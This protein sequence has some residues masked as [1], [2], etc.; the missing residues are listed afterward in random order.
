M[1]DFTTSMASFNLSKVKAEFKTLTIDL[2]ISGLQAEREK[3]D[4]DSAKYK[5]IS[6]KIGNLIEQRG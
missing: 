1:G 6:T 5:E 2:Q 3:F 4:K